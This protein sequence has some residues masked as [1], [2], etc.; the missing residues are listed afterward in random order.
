MIGLELDQLSKTQGQGVMCN[1]TGFDTLVA[2]IGFVIPIGQGVAHGQT[3]GAVQYP[4]L[5]IGEDAQP[6]PPA[7]MV[8]QLVL[9]RRLEFGVSGSGL[10]PIQPPYRIHPDTDRLP[11]Q[12]APVGG[13]SPVPPPTRSGND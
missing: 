8:P 1:R 2:I 10:P 7:R 9:P 5:S 11:L 6:P 12:P 3:E 4:P 13:A